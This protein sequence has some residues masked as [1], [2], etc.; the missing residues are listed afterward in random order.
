MQNSCK[1]KNDWHTIDLAVILTVK[2]FC[3]NI[4]TVSFFKY[5]TI[6]KKSYTVSF[7]YGE[8]FDAQD[9]GRGDAGKTG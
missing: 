1:K 2:F 9:F 3:N 4:D 5:N 7:L 6:N 8:E